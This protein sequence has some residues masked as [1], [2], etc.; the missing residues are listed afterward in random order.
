[1]GRN[2]KWYS[3]LYVSE[4]AQK[5][6]NKILRKLKTN[7]GMLNIYLVTL[8]AN[9]ADML[10]IISAAY[11][12]QPAVRRNLPMIV[13]IACGYDEAVALVVKMLEDTLAATGEVCIPRYLAQKAGAE[14][15]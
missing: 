5:K 9:P 12:K 15:L 7:A 2:M 3:E 10:D 11:L 6:K 13:G 4:N 8:A 1:M 14:R